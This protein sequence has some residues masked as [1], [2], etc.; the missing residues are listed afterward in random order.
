MGFRLWN[1]CEGEPRPHGRVLY[2]RIGSA[3]WMLQLMAFQHSPP[4]PRKHTKSFLHSRQGTVKVHQPG[5]LFQFERAHKCPQTYVVAFAQFCKP[6]AV[7]SSFAPPTEAPKAPRQLATANW[8][9]QKTACQPGAKLLWAIWSSRGS[10]ITFITFSLQFSYSWYF[11]S[12][13]QNSVSTLR[14]FYGKCKGRCLIRVPPIPV[15]FRLKWLLWN[16]E[17]HVDCTGLHKVW[18]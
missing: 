6:H 3:G 9:S 5:K 4:W 15:N 1:H 17:G 7:L 11:L 2:C 18:S 16:V 14:S 8:K 13:S 10:T 12:C